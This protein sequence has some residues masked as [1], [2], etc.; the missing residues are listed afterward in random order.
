ME[1]ISNNKKETGILRLGYWEDKLRAAINKLPEESRT[2]VG[3]ASNLKERYYSRTQEFS[4]DFEEVIKQ[5][6]NLDKNDFVTRAAVLVR[7]FMASHFSLEELERSSLSPHFT[8]ENGENHEKINDLMA[9]EFVKN[10]NVVDAVKI[11]LAPVA[12]KGM[13]TV[14]E[15][16]LSGLVG[17][18]QKLVTNPNFSGVSTIDGYSWLV[19]RYPRLAEKYGFEIDNNNPGHAFIKRQDFINR[20]KVDKT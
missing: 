20:Y 11:H 14:E 7:D 4:N 1:I 3:L 5:I 9:I 2:P 6:S 8:E 10:D 18:A 12:S 17:L 13:R 15:L 16:F 19:S